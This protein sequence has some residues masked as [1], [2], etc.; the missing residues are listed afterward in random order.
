MKNQKKIVEKKSRSF[1]YNAIISKLFLSIIF[2]FSVLILVKSNDFCESFIKDDIFTNSMNFTAFNNFYEKYFGKVVPT[3]NTEEF[4]FN[5][6]F[7]FSSI[8]EYEDYEKIT[9]T[10]S[11]YITSLCGG[12]VVFMGE[13]EDFGY[14]VIVQGNDGYDVWYGNLVNVSVGLYDYIESDDIIGDVL[15]GEL[16][17]SI[18]S[19]D[20]IILYEDYQN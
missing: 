11:S 5:S 1:E 2:L 20:E 9:L 7:V 17:L 6:D 8:E 3:I 16:Y 12:I 10:S 15:D 18:R 19:G 13:K 14:T 4:V